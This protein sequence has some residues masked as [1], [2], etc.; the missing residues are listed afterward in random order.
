MFP[1]V[2]VTEMLSK[3]STK[4][5]TKQHLYMHERKGDFNRFEWLGLE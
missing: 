1:P 4:D 3:Q 2:I 5:A